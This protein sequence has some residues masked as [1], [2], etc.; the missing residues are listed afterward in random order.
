VN[1]G[2]SCVKRIF[3]ARLSGLLHALGQEIDRGELGDP[4]IVFSPHPDDESL[5][6][7]GTIVQKKRVGANATVV[8]MTDGSA[9]HR[10][11]ISE[12]RLKIMRRDEAISACEILGVEAANVVFLDFK[13]GQLGACHHA[14]VQKVSAILRQH[15][16]EQIFI[17]YSNDATPDHQATHAIVLA[18]LRE[19]RKS[20]VVYEYPVWF[21]AHWPWVSV[22][23]A[24]PSQVIQQT[25]SSLSSWI[26]LLKDFRCFVPITEVM[27]QKRTALKQHRS[28]TTRLLPD[29]RWPVL[30]DVADG[31]FLACFFQEHEVFYRYTTRELFRYHSSAP[32]TRAAIL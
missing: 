6:C 4:C 11:F 20:V 29:F 31:E 8:F 7:G 25:M 19:S 28:Q 15:V 3:R 22:P 17:P 27:E 9:S 2:K 26:R 24:S 14:A 32:A 21:W 1:K 5:G 30:S 13:D 23:I 10:R 16:A 18:A 12:Q